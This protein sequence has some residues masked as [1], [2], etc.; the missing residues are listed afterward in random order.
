M[1]KLE[2]I[3]IVGGG[4]AGFV[5]ALILKA[6]FPNKEISVVCSKK[7]GIIGVG[8]GSTE[9][10]NEFMKYIGVSF[11]QVIQECDA[12]FK[13]GIMFKGWA[14]NDYLHSIG[15]ESQFLHGQYPINY[16]HLISNKAKN[17]EFNSS[18]TW[19]NKVATKFLNDDIENPPFNQYHFNTNKLN[20]FLTTLAMVKNIEVFYDEI[21]D[22]SLNEDGEIDQLIC[23]KN[24]HQA[25]F[26]IDCTGFNRLLMNKLGAKW[27]SYSKYL[28][29]KS[30]IV[31]PIGDTKEY[32][33]WTTAQAMDYGWMFK[34]PVWGRSGNGYIFDSDYITPEQAK[35]EVE[36][37]IGHEIDI[38]KHITF[39][40][41]ALDKVWIKNCCAVGLSASFVEP[42]EATSIGTSIQQTFLL[43]HRLPNYDN[44]TI[45]KYNKDVNDILINIR[46]FV[47]LHYITKKQNTIFWHDISKIELP[48]TLK[49]NLDRWNKNLPIFDDF[50]DITNYRLFNSTNYL[51]IMAPLGLFDVEKIKEEYNMFGDYYKNKS[52]ETLYNLK[53]EELKTPKIGHKEFITRIRQKVGK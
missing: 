31:F 23:S 30:A 36:K 2:K 3:T 47:L 25:D 34:I 11:Q 22:I 13:S 20:D 29:M 18:F 51:Q 24:N 32:N 9:H 14:E 7:I 15:Q 38:G 44:N 6:R 5:C 49:N 42:L 16:G 40:P 53:I 28:K 4:T 48:D 10:W 12:T 21:L 19:N 8:E 45:D 43:M 35:L 17:R 52:K 1:K 39:D 33:I 41:G 37:F 27:Q 46:D 26:F 50:S